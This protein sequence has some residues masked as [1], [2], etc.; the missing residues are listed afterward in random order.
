MYITPPREAHF[1]HGTFSNV[2]CRRVSFPFIKRGGKKKNQSPARCFSFCRQSHHPGCLSFASFIADD[3]R[4]GFP[5]FSLSK[6]KGKKNARGREERSRGGRDVKKKEREKRR[7]KK[8][9]EKC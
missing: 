1:K 8:Q 4:I 2:G 6:R 5:G 9:S 7:E 3:L